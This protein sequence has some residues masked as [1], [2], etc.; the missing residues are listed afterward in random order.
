MIS[1]SKYFLL[2][3]GV[4]NAAINLPLQCPVNSRRKSYDLRKP[5]GHLHAYLHARRVK[6]Q[7]RQAQP[8]T[9]SPLINPTKAAEGPDHW[10]EVV[11]NLSSSLK[12]EW[13]EWVVK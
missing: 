9:A 8:P 3:Y 11:L 5:N 12:S 4:S 1:V 2:P 7:P 10:F 6:A 13:A